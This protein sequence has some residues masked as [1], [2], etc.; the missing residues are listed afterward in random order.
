[1]LLPCKV[2][3][4]GIAILRLDERIRKFPHGEKAVSQ[5]IGAI[6]NDYTDKQGRID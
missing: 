1:M 4:R 6:T 3:I 2:R 5:A